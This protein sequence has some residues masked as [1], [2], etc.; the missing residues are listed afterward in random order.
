[1]GAFL[2][3]ALAIEGDRAEAAEL[4]QRARAGALLSDIVPQLFRRG[5]MLHVH[6]ARGEVAEA[7]GL[8]DQLLRLIDRIDYPE[9]EFYARLD[10]AEGYRVVGHAEHAAALIA[11]AL[12]DSRARQAHAF[13][14]QAEAARDLVRLV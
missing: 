6:A 14:R 7:V 3:H 1:M 8:A 4:A 5:A 9:L 13:V 11:R 12:A 2:A 10:A